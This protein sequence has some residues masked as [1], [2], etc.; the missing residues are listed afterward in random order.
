MSYS[1]D[2]LSCR[3]CDS[4]HVKDISKASD[5]SRGYFVYECQNC[6]QRFEVEHN[7]FTDQ[8]V[9]YEDKEY[10]YYK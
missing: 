9:E 6:C 3:V 1:T 10:E 2:Q 7:M 4:L 5:I 8:E